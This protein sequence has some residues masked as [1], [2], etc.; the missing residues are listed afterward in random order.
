[1]EAKTVYDDV[2]E[3]IAGMN[4]QKVIEFKASPKNQLRFDSLLEKNANN[5]LSVQEKIEMDHYLVLNRIIG[6][7]KARALSMSGL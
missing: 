3:F 2:A 4:S 1:M 5:G 6:L 7:A